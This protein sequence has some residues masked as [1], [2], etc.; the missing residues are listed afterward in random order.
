MMTSQIS[1][2]LNGSRSHDLGGGRCAERTRIIAFADRLNA[3][4][5]ACVTRKECI[6]YDN[7]LTVG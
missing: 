1:A 2:L 6:E 5:G 4:I 3:P 7:P